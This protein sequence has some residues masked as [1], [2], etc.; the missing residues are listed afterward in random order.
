VA[1]ALGIEIAGTQLTLTSAADDLRL[2][3]SAELA[4]FRA[5]AA[6]PELRLSVDWL[7]P[8]TGRAAL[9]KARVLFDSGKLW[10]LLETEGS[11]GQAA[12]RW[13]RFVSRRYGEAPYKLACLERPDGSAGTIYVDR[14]CAMDGEVNALEYPLDELLFMHWL[15]TRRGVIVHSCGVVDA[16]GRGYLFVGQSGAG[17]STTARLWLK[18]RGVT[19]LSDDRIVVQERN[20]VFWMS[21]TPWHG[22]AGLAAQGSVPISRVFLLAQAP[23]GKLDD[24]PRPVA[25]ARLLA[26]SFFP[27]HDRSAL[28][29]TA[30]LLAD[31]V[32][33]VGCQ[34]LSFAPDISAVDTVLRVVPPFT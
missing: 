20:G 30:R 14:R 2:G 17:K 19:I 13:F 9:D 29:D 4:P 10:Q 32:A 21:G 25:T 1:E 34:Q 16:D 26:A 31:L 27:F 22:E 15:P 3:L 18:G 28:A 12:Q 24:V 8:T 6:A 7:T 23:T 5:P 33:Q 11:G